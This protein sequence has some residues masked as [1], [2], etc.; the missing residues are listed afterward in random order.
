VQLNQNANVGAACLLHTRSFRTTGLRDLCYASGTS[1][2]SNPILLVAAELHVFQIQVA[3]E[4]QF[5]R[6]RLCGRAFITFLETQLVWM[7]KN[8]KQ[9]GE[10]Y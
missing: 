1:L 3:N 2:A 8:K 6:Q 5:L 9:L 4:E 10:D 7:M